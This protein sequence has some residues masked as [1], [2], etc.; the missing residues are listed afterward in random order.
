MIE[1]IIEFS[2]RNRFFVFLIITFLLAWGLWA[3]W[4]TALDAIPD[5][6]D[7]QVIVFTE[8]PG[9][10]PDLLEDQITYPIVTAMLAAP[11]VQ[12]VRGISDFGFSYVY[13][14]FKD[15]TDMYWARSRVLEYLQ[16]ITGQLPEGT[17]P[18]LGPDATGVGWVFEYALVDETGRHNLAQLRSFQDWY[19]RYWLESVPGVAEVAS[20]GGFV[21]QYQVE[22]D[23]NK[24]LAYNIPIGQAISAIRRSNNDVGGRVLEIASSE[25]MVRG[26]GYIQTLRD[27]EAVPVG[28][29]GR[30][31]PILVRDLGRVHYGPDM[32]RGVAELDG[33]G[34]V[35]GGIVVMRYGENALDVVNRVKQKLS[36][37]EGSL[38]EGVEVVVTYDRSDLILRAIETLKNKLSE[39]MIVVSIVI[40][41]FLLHFRTALIP[42]LA[43]PMAVLMSFIP[44][45]YMNLTANIMSLG[46]I[47]IAIGAMVDASIVL[48]ENA[49]KNLDRW[50]SEGKPGRRTEVLIQSFREVG[51]SIFFAL[52]V[53]TI[54]FLPVFTLQAQEGRLF[55][56]LAYT[57]TF[58]M[59]FAA[60]LAVTL[61]PALGTLLIRGKI[62][63]EKKHP[64]SRL[65]FFLYTP[66]LNT[67]LRF[68]RSFIFM[69]LVLVVS[70]VPVFM[71]LGSEFMPPLNEGSLL[72]MPTAVPGMPVTEAAKILQTQDKLLR[73]FPEVERV[74]GKIG[75]AKTSTDPAPLS[76]VE[77]VVLLK[78]QQQWETKHQERWYSDW[79]PESLKASFRFFWPEE[80]T[81]TWE[82]MVEEMDAQLKFPGMAN[83]WWM[84]VQ[85]RTEMLST[86]IR[87]NL[88]IKVFGPNLETI[89]RIGVEIENVLQDVPGTRSAFAD[90][91]M[92][93][94]YVDF[95]VKRF[96][97]ARYGLTVDDVLEIVETA[98]G[99][100]NIAY[101][102]EGRERYPI[103]VRYPRELRDN[104]EALRKVLVPTP[105]GAQVP[106]SLLADI[107]YMQG[108]PMIRDEDGQLVGYVF[109]DVTDQDY[110]G[111]VNR[112]Q[113]IVREKL[114]LPAGYRIEWA[115]QYKYLLRMKQRL[116]YIIPLTLFIVFVLLYIN[117]GSWKEPIIVFLA[118]P[119]SLIGSFWLLYWL[120]YNLSVA[121]WV[122]IIALAGLDAE[123]GT[124]MLLYLLMAHKRWQKEGKMQTVDH[125]KESI[126]H[127]AVQR[128]RPKVMTVFTTTIGLLPIMWASTYEIGADVMKRMAAPMVGGLVTS[129]ILELTIYPAIFLLW[130]GTE[131]EGWRSL[132]PGLAPRRKE[133]VEKQVAPERRSVLR[134]VGI[135]LG[136]L[137]AGLL[138]WGIWNWFQGP[139]E[140]S[141][142]E[143]VVQQAVAGTQVEIL[144]PQ[145]RFT[146][147]RSSFR[148]TFQTARGEPVEV[149]N[150]RIEF[151]MPAMAAMPAMHA[152]ADVDPAGPG[153]FSAQVDLPMAGEWQV[154]LSLD[155]P[156]GPKNLRTTIRA[157]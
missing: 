18:T 6:S 53:I 110:E 31:T 8:W 74:F 123:T 90:R 14:I 55:Q 29:D 85:T 91:V 26:R 82:E 15:G 154:R 17:T 102:I 3:L 72:F 117:F 22:L 34:E 87:S 48:V 43:L 145:G 5:L 41:V 30:G 150:V 151:H 125:L 52:L 92:G 105:T 156:D 153:T 127:G 32:R 9:R 139:A 113:Q 136:V 2:A 38:P 25:Y 107:S 98:V 39:E 148:V 44:L 66:V 33:R 77:T 71:R 7:V 27:I 79:L 23:P 146:S 49:H 103:N 109:V 47:A 89:E 93:G 46:G 37:V 35:V 36:D 128:V 63:S 11:R 101:T 81:K 69:A 155:T 108:P 73:Q 4:N 130:K 42:I 51:P 142:M 129:F 96:E 122:G 68:P 76:M 1:R 147:G 20:V 28:T 61:V 83:I 45:Y 65:L 132:I 95:K 135:L 140:V 12:L 88:G 64:I 62:R 149:Q 13:V 94:Y 78:P 119:F 104:I 58:S 40:V 138:A 100:K 21:K 137:L 56:P 24:L 84:P 124:I 144:V 120:D 106:I 133:Q 57:K 16:K 75:R 116:T 19:L 86:G 121:V 59:F 80:R 143:P 152:T 60:L 141:S 99:G 67:V 157:Q 126:H 111:Y 54:S 50:A 118:V 114:D 10:S 115:G 131:V 134:L 97:A 112:A 70:T